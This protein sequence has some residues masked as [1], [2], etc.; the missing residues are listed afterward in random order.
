MK[1]YNLIITLVQMATFQFTE[2]TLLLIFPLFFFRCMLFQ[3]NRTLINSFFPSRF[4]IVPFW[5]GSSQKKFRRTPINVWSKLIVGV[6]KKNMW[7]N[8][9]L[10]SNLNVRFFIRNICSIKWSCFF[11]FTL[12]I[13]PS[14]TR[15]EKGPTEP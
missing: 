11:S 6:E 3:Q 4:S 12:I 9:N 13:F 15:K 5:N 1:A 2:I 8:E 10:R 14:W 7:W